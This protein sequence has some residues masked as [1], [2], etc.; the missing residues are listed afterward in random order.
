MIDDWRYNDGNMMA[1]QF[2]L[3]AFIH[4]GIDLNKDVYEFCHN[5]VSEGRFQKHLD[6][7]REGTAA[8]SDDWENEMQSD[9]LAGWEEYLKTAPAPSHVLV[10][11]PEASPVG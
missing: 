5:Y 3:N 8:V 11:D 1:R 7:L 10:P 4:K 2:C 9:V 6:S